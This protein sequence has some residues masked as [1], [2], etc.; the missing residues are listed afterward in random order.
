MASVV[1]VEDDRVTM[2]ILE[3]ALSEAGLEVLIAEDGMKGLDLIQTTRP[4]IAIIDM[5]IPKLHGV[6]LCKRIKEN[7][8]LKDVKIIL[9]SAV[10]KY[11]TFRM[12]IEEAEADYFVNKPLDIPRLLGFIDQIIGPKGSRKV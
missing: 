9:M 6:E 12:D 7:N 2:K 4:D 5:L 1:I 8:L 11:T 10:Y 3:K